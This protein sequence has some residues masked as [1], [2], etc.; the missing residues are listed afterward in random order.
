MIQD[1]ARLYIRHVLD[2]LGVNATELARSAGVSH[3]TI[4][5][6]VDPSRSIVV[7][8]RTLLAIEHATGL[9]LEDFQAGR[10]AR[11]AEAGFERVEVFDPSRVP[12]GGTLRD[13]EPPV[14]AMAF[15][16][17][18][19]ASL[20]GAG[21][22]PVVGLR[23]LGDAMEPTLADGDV[24]LVDAGARD[25]ARGGLMVLGGPGGAAIRRV[26]IEPGTTRVQVRPDHRAYDAHH[27][28]AASLEVLG[29]VVWSGGR[30]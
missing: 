7:S 10:A 2:A 1:P 20:A 30:L 25:L 9:T 26:S 17:D 3:S 4:H 15:P 14:M 11:P 16:R 19:L 8:R 5:R 18:W 23:V 21:G 22:G 29:R 6:A 13:A 28:E 12:P 24:V 27:A